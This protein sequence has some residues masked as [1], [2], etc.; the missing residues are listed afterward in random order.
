MKFYAALG[1]HDDPTQRLYKLFNMNGERFYSFK[2]PR[3]SVRFF[4]LDSNYMSG[5][6]EVAR[7]G[8]TG[9]RFGLE[10]CL[11]SPSSLFIRGTARA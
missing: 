11:F 7:E 1:N 10:D 8:A 4:A 9:Q 5:A 2:A 6:A 3:G